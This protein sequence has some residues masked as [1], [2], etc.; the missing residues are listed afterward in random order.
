MECRVWSGGNSYKVVISCDSSSLMSTS[1]SVRE[2]KFN[3]QIQFVIQNMSSRT[4]IFCSSKELFRW[5]DKFMYNSVYWRYSILMSVIMWTWP[6]LR[7][8]QTSDYQVP[9]LRLTLLLLWRQSGALE[10]GA[11]PAQTLNVICHDTCSLARP[12][13][14]LTSCLN[15]DN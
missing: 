5:I 15:R 4:K 9:A 8:S 7:S 14:H 13:S 6:L 3:K 2:L 12:T 10:P 11:N 1:Q